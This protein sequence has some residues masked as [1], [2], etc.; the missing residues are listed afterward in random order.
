MIKLLNILKE[1]SIEPVEIGNIF[2][3]FI[4]DVNELTHI[5]RSEYGLLGHAS[6]DIII[7]DVKIV[8]TRVEKDPIPYAILYVKYNII[9]PDRTYP[10]KLIINM[11]NTKDIRIVEKILN[12]EDIAYDSYEGTTHDIE[13][14]NYNGE[15]FCYYIS[16]EVTDTPINSYQTTIFDAE[17]EDLRLSEIT[18]Q[19]VEIGGEIEVYK[20]I[21][22]DNILD[23]IIKLKGYATGLKRDKDGEII[24]KLS[25]KPIERSTN[26]RNRPIFDKP[27]VFYLYLLY[28][29]HVW[30]NGSQY[31]KGEDTGERY[32]VSLNKSSIS[33]SKVKI[34]INNYIFYIGEKVNVDGDLIVTF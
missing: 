22:S 19:P 34:D 2:A 9:R 16:H 6:K 12:N 29:G 17:V 33:G 14:T 8:K 23:V 20:N 31:V 21:I 15:T 28:K 3:G 27:D 5:L 26:P 4:R 18:I 7:D 11:F 24:F 13:H 10:T 1:I 30:D 25:N 32:T